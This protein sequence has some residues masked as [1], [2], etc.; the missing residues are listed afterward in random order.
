MPVCSRLRF[1]LKALKVIADLE[2]AGLSEQDA[3]KAFGLSERSIKSI[4]KKG[5]AYYLPAVY[6]E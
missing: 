4:K 6:S 2:T 1:N 3:A 5:K